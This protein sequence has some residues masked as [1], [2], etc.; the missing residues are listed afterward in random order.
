MANWEA[1]KE[2]ELCAFTGR[3]GACTGS[4]EG[5][6]MG[7]LDGGWTVTSRQASSSSS[8][9]SSFFFSSIYQLP[10]CVGELLH[11][12]KLRFTK[13]KTGCVSGY[14]IWTQHKS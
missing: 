8:S 13:S 12:A 11:P 14:G 9:F 5:G 4:Y 3:L 10:T 1:N 7:S 2:R 6:Y